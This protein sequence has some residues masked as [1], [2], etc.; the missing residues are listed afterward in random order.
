MNAPLI[1]LLEV[2]ELVVLAALAAGTVWLVVRSLPATLEAR[3]KHIE[4][5]VA[6]FSTRLTE[7]IDERAVWKLQGERLAEEVETYL[8]QIERKRASTAASASRIAGTQPAA[9]VPIEKMPRS[10][11]LKWARRQNSG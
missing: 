11:Q 7:I 2:F 5:V 3:Q 10:D 1:P 9:Q 4:T 8:G 6:G